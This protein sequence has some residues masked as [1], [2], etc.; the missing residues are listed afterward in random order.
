MFSFSCELAACSS[1]N[2][3]LNKMFSLIL[4]LIVIFI[5]WKICSAI[6]HDPLTNFSKTSVPVIRNSL[7]L[8]WHK[9]GEF[10]ISLWTFGHNKNNLFKDEL[11]RF[12]RECATTL[13]KSYQHYFFTRLSYN[14]I[15]AEDA[16]KVLGSS[17]HI[18]KSFV[19]Y[20]LQ[21]FLKT[22]LLTSNGDKW[23]TRR[24]LLTPAFHFDI[25][26]EFFEVFKEESDKLV[27]SLKPKVGKV[28]DIIPVSS[29]FTLNTICGKTKL[30]TFRCN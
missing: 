21:P 28:L 15:R 27:E 7:N 3:I 9:P 8:A 10:Y 23:H 14:V 25:L 13:K 11:F 1:V 17:K 16:E 6:K 4:T 19:Y 18:D 2:E 26:K 29:Q 5:V 12:G 20:F 24:R 30:K 22:G